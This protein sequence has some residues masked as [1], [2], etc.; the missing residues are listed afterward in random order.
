MRIGT[1]AGAI[2][3]VD[4]TIIEVQGD[5]RAADIMGMIV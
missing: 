1:A 5:R 2:W 4:D 3:V